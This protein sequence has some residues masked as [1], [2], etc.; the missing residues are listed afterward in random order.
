[1]PRKCFGPGCKNEL[2]GRQ[3]KWCSDACRKKANRARQRTVRVRVVKRPGLSGYAQ[4]YEGYTVHFSLKIKAK[5]VQ[6]VPALGNY[7]VDAH[8]RRY[9]NCEIYA[10][11]I[12]EAM[13]E[14]AFGYNVDVEVHLT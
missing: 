6:A 3:R 5:A 7:H 13:N 9:E 10:R 14:I 1:M 11:L 12:E 2:T 8:L 4:D